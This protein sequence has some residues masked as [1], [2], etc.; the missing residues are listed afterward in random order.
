MSIDPV[1]PFRSRTATTSGGAP[2]SHATLRGVHPGP[3]MWSRDAPASI[4][5][6]T[7]SGCTFSAAAT[8]STF[9][10]AQAD[11]SQLL[12]AHQSCTDAP[13]RI[14]TRTTSGS[15]VNCAAMQIGDCRFSFRPVTS[16]PA[17]MH[18]STSSTLAREKKRCVFQL[19]Q[20]SAAASGSVASPQAVTN[21]KIAR[22]RL[23][24]SDS[25]AVCGFSS[26]LPCVRLL[27]VA[28]PVLPRQLTELA[29]T[30]K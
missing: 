14:S 29:K 6:C 1:A 8:C 5:A 28:L 19:A 26:R 21:A 13:L 20:R 12:K 2:K 4:R 9:A 3:A 11:R 15:L 25:Y 30:S 7:T 24:E 17:R 22:N 10:R 16:L 23:I 27:W 18:A